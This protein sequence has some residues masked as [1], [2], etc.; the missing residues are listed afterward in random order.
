M[1]S[2]NEIYESGV[3]SYEAKPHDGSIQKNE[4]QT[5]PFLKKSCLEISIE[6]SEIPKDK[7]QI[8]KQGAICAYFICNLPFDC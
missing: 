3:M 6:Q 4:T 5:K 7:P 2:M 1:I 8:D